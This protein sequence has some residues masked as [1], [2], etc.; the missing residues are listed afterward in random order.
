M[1]NGLLGGGVNNGMG[2]AVNNRLGGG[3]PTGL[4]GVE[5]TVFLCLSKSLLEFFDL[6]FVE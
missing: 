4:G 3:V 2:G 5:C 6:N 1:S